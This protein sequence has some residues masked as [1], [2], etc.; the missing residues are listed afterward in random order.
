DLVGRIADLMVQRDVGRVPIVDSKAR[1]I[2]LVARKDLLRIRA[3]QNLE[4]TERRGYLGRS[5]KAALST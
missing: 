5:D 4:E 2:G 3:A 1:L